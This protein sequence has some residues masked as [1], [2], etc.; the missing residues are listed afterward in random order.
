MKSVN[1]NSKSK[2]MNNTMAGNVVAGDEKTGG[3]FVKVEDNLVPAF[4]TKNGYEYF[5][6]RPAGKVMRG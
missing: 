5:V 6:I 4:P 1:T 2:S 3:K